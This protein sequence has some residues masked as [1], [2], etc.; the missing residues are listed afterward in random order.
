[1]KI[2]KTLVLNKDYQPYNLFPLQTIEASEAIKRVINGTCLVVTEYDRLIK[3][4]NHKINWPSIVVTCDYVKL[5]RIAILRKESLFYR[6]GKKCAYCLQALKESE[7][8]MDHVIPKGRGGRHIWENIVISCS[9]C[10]HKKAMNLPNNNWK[11]KT[12]PYKP[13][14]GQLIKIRKNYPIKV[15]HE[16][17]IDFIGPWNAKIIIEK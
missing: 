12:I 15:Y 2:P 3:T 9:D 4:P 7:S 17:W 10:N 1:M 11:P 8:T 16:S 13:T 6:D 14:Y 5:E